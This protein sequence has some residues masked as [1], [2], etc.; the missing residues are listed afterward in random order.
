MTGPIEDIFQVL[1]LDR[2][3]GTEDAKA[4]GKVSR[5]EISRAEI[6]EDK[7]RRPDA[8][9]PWLP[10]PFQ[11]PAV[12]SAL[13]LDVDNMIDQAKHSAVTNMLDKWLES[14]QK[15]GEDKRADEA[16]RIQELLNRL[17]TAGTEGIVPQGAEGNSASL[18]AV[19]AL[20]V[21]A[22]SVVSGVGGAAAISQPGLITINELSAIAASLGIVPGQFIG[23]LG[24]LGALFATAA[25]YPTLAQTL[26]DAKGETKK[27]DDAQFAKNYLEQVKRL[28][29]NPDFDKLAKYTI[30]ARADAS[31][32]SEKLIAVV[33]L[34][35]LFTAI[36]LY[37]KVETGHLTGQEVAGLVNGEIKLPD[38]DPRLPLVKLIKESFTDI[39]EEE[40]AQLLEGFFEYFDKNPKVDELVEPNSLLRSLGDNRDSD[41]ITK[42][43]G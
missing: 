15:L 6:E 3:A 34:V 10:Y 19:T 31:E 4:D 23:A 36:A 17:F 32:V 27:I 41:R 16:E 35:L 18:A 9:F 22:S 11:P 7:G 39:P 30:I 2:V 37:Y 1:R 24:L 33:K 26:K 12:D 40:L 43:S 21:I 38:D 20:L 5:D 28:I 13:S 25:F 42:T 8:A 29:E 14:L